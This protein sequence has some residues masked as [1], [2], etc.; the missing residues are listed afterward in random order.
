MSCCPVGAKK[1]D[2]E[3]TGAIDLGEQKVE[4]LKATMYEA[5]AKIM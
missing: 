2:Q 4:Q 5:A 3:K 1:N